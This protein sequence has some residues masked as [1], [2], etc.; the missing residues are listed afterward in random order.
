M[1]LEEILIHFHDVKKTGNGWQALCPA[2][3]DQNRSLSI[4]QGDDGRILL[5]CHAGCETADIIKA[6]GLQMSDLFTNRGKGSSL[7]V[8][9]AHLRTTELTNENNNKNKCAAKCAVCNLVQYAAAKRL[10]SSG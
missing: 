4:S 8:P 7:R 6:V 5:K 10:G 1:T 3:N 9:T 2:H